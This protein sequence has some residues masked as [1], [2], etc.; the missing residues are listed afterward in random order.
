M[1]TPEAHDRRL[2]AITNALITETEP[3]TLFR[4]VADHLREWLPFA[5]LGIS[6]FDAETGAFERGVAVTPSGTMQ[7][8]EP[9]PFRGTL[10]E[11]IAAG[12]NAAVLSAGQLE[13]TLSRF[14]SLRDPSDDQALLCVVLPLFGRSHNLLA[15]AAATLP[16]STPIAP[17]DLEFLNRLGIQI[18][19]A[20]EN[21]LLHQENARLRRQL[22]QD[23]RYLREEINEAFDVSGLM[24]ASHGIAEVMAQVRKAAAT[25][26]TVLLIGETGTGKELFARTIHA[27]SPKSHRPLVKV[28]CGAIPSGLIESTLFGH[29]KGAFTGAVNRHIGLFEVADGGTL[30]LDEIGELPLE[31]QVKLLRVLQEGEFTRVGGHETLKT[32]V[33]VIA[34]TNRSLESMVQEGSFRADLY[35][36]LAVIPVIIPPLRERPDDI[37]LL[38][39]AFVQKFARRVHKPIKMIS[40]DAMRRLTAYPFPGNVRE[41]ENLI[42]RAVVLCES[43]V[44]GPEFFPIGKQGIPQPSPKAPRSSPTA[45]KGEPRR[46]E[47]QEIL[48]VLEASNWLIEGPRGAA[49]KLGLKPSTLRGRMAKLGITRAAMER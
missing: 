27:Q 45:P 7:S 36:R 48:S 12:G 17:A 9:I 2:L 11:G 26:A 21:M 15:V 6:Y 34:A 35:Y 29:E 39:T 43:T 49:L 24:Y 46:G 1:S 37:P 14:V 8:I 19:L 44:L 30:F 13:Q 10:L 40:P 18:G 5:S 23:G 47:R 42:E 20:V 33:R 38:A 16:A 3:A 32:A 31:M 25:D 4:T 28:N 22:E 41:L